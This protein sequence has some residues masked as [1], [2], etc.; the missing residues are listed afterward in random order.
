MCELFHKLSRHRHPRG[1]TLAE[2]MVAMSLALLL[3]GMTL[4]F[5]NQLYN[6]SDLAGSA[7]GVNQNL[8]AAVNLIVRDLSMAGAEIPLGG[9]PIPS[10]GTAT[11]IIRP[12]PGANTFPATGAVAVITPGPGLGPTTGSGGTAIPTDT[13]TLISVNP[14][15][16]LDQ[17]PLTALSYTT[18]SATITVNA[19]TNIATG[20]SEVSPGQLIM[21]QNANA[22]CILAVSA[23]NT[24][25]NTITFNH[26]DLA[27]VLGLNQFSGAT[28]GTITQLLATGIPP[29]PA[30][31]AYHINMVT[32]YLDTS[33]PP[34]LMRQVGTGTAQPVALGIGVLQFSYSLS[35][36]ATP[37][38]PTRTV[39]T[40]NQIRKVNLWVIAIA[41]HKN[42]GTGRY[43]SN[44]IA[45]SAVIQNLAYYNK[46]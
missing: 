26:G 9:I 35:P 8:R 32:Y 27:D 30:V 42:L 16:L 31:T 46:Y 17:Y 13:I 39:A 22:S 37:V 21:L 33:T 12:G 23:V 41:D 10:G 29:S 36:P 20:A 18:T 2:L 1:F 4:S 45:T 3:L 43:Y 24:T 15:S 19:S 5:L 44:S 25:T 28:T 38:D 14:I 7:A 40:P 34:R 6:T 11:P